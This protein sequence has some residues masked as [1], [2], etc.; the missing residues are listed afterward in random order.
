MNTAVVSFLRAKTGD[1]ILAC[2]KTRHIDMG[3]SLWRS[4]NYLFAVISLYE[5]KFYFA[6]QR[7][8]LYSS[9]RHIIKKVFI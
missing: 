3:C 8:G 7:S 5:S 2:G 9:F 6:V 1:K 4:I